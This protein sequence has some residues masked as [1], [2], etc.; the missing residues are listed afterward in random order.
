MTLA[1]RF[2]QLDNLVGSCLKKKKIK[3]AVWQ[4]ILND[5]LIFRQA[6]VELHHFSS[7]VS[8]SPKYVYSLT[9]LASQSCPC[10]SPQLTLP[11]EKAALDY[12]FW[13]GDYNNEGRAI[14]GAQNICVV[15]LYAK[16]LRWKGWVKPL[17]LS[18]SSLP[19]SVTGSNLGQSSIIPGC[20][21]PTIPRT[22]NWISCSQASL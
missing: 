1:T 8:H 19:A 6:V 16:M 4:S 21:R 15:S 13:M 9:G 5:F 3:A 12:V 22:W 2:W 7:K 10:P 11:S 14:L 17:T 18:S 20:A